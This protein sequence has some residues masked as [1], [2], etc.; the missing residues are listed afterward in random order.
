M[1]QCRPHVR[2]KSEIVF[3]LAAKMSM[4]TF[5][6]SGEIVDFNGENGIILA[7]KSRILAAKT[8]IIEFKIHFEYTGSYSTS[9]IIF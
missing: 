3:F 1:A 5:Q 2:P 7:A 4:A 9:R 8:W 6:N